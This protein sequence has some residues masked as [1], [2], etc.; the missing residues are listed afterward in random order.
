V[1]PL[2]AAILEHHEPGPARHTDLSGV[3][4]K[5]RGGLAGVACE[6]QPGSLAAQAWPAGEIT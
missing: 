2:A 4:G 1:P 6:Q 3:G 5:R